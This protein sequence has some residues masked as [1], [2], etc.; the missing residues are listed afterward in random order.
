M[1]ILAY[2]IF[3][4]GVICNNNALNKD[5]HHYHLHLHHHHPFEAKE[6]K[7]SNRADI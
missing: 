6:S 1:Q 5:Y 2:F 7:R 4:E 3:R